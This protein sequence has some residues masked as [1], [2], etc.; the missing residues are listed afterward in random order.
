MRE[1]NLVLRFTLEL[2]AL[3]AVGYAGLEAADGALGWLLAA[4]P[5]AAIVIVWA[6]FVSPKHTIE[7]PRPVAF[8]IELVVWAAASAALASTG[9]VTL[10]VVFL[11]VSVVS[12]ALNYAWR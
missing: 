2:G 11:A 8:G 9:H 1:A 12:G 7:T 3:G 6:L 10:G 4:L 5:V